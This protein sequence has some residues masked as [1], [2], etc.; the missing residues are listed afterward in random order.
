M[1]SCINSDAFC[2]NAFKVT[3]ATLLN[4]ANKIPKQNVH[5]KRI[6]FK[7]LLTLL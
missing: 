4:V 3:R 7:F 1:F 5:F 6:P 2:Q